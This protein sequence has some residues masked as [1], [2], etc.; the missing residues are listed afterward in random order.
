MPGSP[1]P[2]TPGRTAW[3]P[4]AGSPLG[5][6]GGWATVP[7]LGT[8]AEEGALRWAH[9]AHSAR[10]RL[11]RVLAAASKARGRSQQTK[12]APP[13]G[14]PP[15][16]EGSPGA[17]REHREQPPSR[18]DA[19]EGRPETMRTGPTLQR[20]RASYLPGRGSGGGGGGTARSAEEVRPSSAAQSGRARLG[21]SER[22]GRGA[23][24]R[25]RGGEKRRSFPT[26]LCRPTR[27]AHQGPASAACSAPLQAPPHHSLPPLTPPPP[28]PPH[29]LPH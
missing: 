27:L 25:G 3:D 28:S 7:S 1:P 5:V 26:P 19:H 23:E 14:P 11:R 24:G 12:P 13:A 4:E 21:P 8:G 20:G 6:G 9:S 2:Q 22:R 16:R 10:V 29:T 15:A 17:E 18:E